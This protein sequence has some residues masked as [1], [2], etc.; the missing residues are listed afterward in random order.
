MKP[1]SILISRLPLCLID[2]RN[3]FGF[4]WEAVQ[5]VTGDLHAKARRDPEALSGMFP[6][7][8]VEGWARDWFLRYEAPAECSTAPPLKTRWRR[9][10]HGSGHAPGGSL[11]IRGGEPVRDV[12]RGLAGAVWRV[13]IGAIR[14]TPQI[15]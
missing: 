3:S 14:W 7:E 11:A 13:N 1:F 2:V 12:G 4:T 15:F 8:E 9:S 5:L 10:L 6:P